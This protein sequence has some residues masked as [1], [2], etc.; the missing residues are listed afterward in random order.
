[1]AL[2]ILGKQKGILMVIVTCPTLL[3]AKLTLFSV[4]P[5][6]FPSRVT[7]RD[8]EEKLYPARDCGRCCQ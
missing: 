2:E 3:T 4:S 5:V 7:L 6:P 8:F 1:M